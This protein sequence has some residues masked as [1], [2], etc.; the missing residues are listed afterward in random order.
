MSDAG[1]SSL[2]VERNDDID[3]LGIITRKDIVEVLMSE[4]ET[5]GR[6]LRVK[7]IMSKPSI[8]VSPN[9]SIFRCFQM[10]GK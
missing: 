1:V 9:L 3:A 4:F 10:I 6:S 7:D 5:N 2:I 8:T